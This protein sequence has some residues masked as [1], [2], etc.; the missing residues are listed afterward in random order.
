MAFGGARRFVGLGFGPIQAGL[1]VYEAQRTRAYAPP[2]VVDVRADLVAGL[3][4]DGGSFRV[5]IARADRTDVAEV[6]PVEVADS[7]VAG[8]RATIIEAIAATD[9][10][11][12]ALPSVGFYRSEAPHSPHLLLAEGLRHRVAPQPLIVYCAENHREAAA[13][14][15]EAVLDAVEPAKRDEVR[16][17]A[18][19]VDTVIGK[20]SGVISDPAELSALGLATITSALPSAFLVEEF[21]RILV[22]RVDPTDGAHVLH[23]GLPVLREVD[24]LAPF[25]AAKLLGHNATHAL[26]GFLGRLLDLGLV[27]DLQRV[28]GAMAFLRAAFLEESGQTLCAR[29]AGADVLFTPNGYAAFADDLMARMVNPHLADTVAR[30]ARDPRR[31]LGWEDRL[32]GL[33]RLGLTEGV[34]TPRYAMGVA[35]GLDMLRRDEGGGDG[36]LPDLLTSCWP[37]DVD[38]AE[39][40]AVLHVVDEGYAWL[41]RWRTGGFAAL[42]GPLAGGWGS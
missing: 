29:F 3:R 7:T 24:D 40:R 22:S 4:A 26:A 37:D 23:P 16:A 13:L 8:E 32:I 41:E 17:R 15:E 5:N 18:R 2:L 36:N 1:F 6:G 21:D 34:A 19:W 11:A 14:L 42:P 12:T 10:L 9:E 28:S 35:A 38:A 31:K 25:E 27:A 30:A 39:A 20:M 33:I